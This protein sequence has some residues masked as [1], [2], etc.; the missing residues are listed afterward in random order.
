MASFRSPSNRTWF[1]VG[2]AGVCATVAWWWPGLTGQ[3]S[4]LDIAI[5]E[6]E[7]LIDS[8]DVLD[9]RLREEGFTTDWFESSSENCGLSEPDTP[10]ERLV[11]VLPEVA[12][13]S[14][15]DV[16]RALNQLLRNIEKDTLV[17]VVAW[18]DERTP[19]AI[20]DLTQDFDARIVDSRRLLGPSGQ[21]MPCLWWDDCPAD[22]LVTVVDN[23]RLTDAGRQRLARSIVAGVL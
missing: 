9:R 1:V 3:D 15:V 2:V 11:V 22:G 18:S 6:H 19:A 16:R 4:Q 7:T 20:A 14:S 23:D 21:M 10:Y 8:R 13:C 17:I 5:I 12:V